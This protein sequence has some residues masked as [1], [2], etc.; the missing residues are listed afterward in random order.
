MNNLVFIKHIGDK[1]CYLFEVPMSVN[2][3]KEDKVFCDTMYARQFGE[4]ITDS[5]Y[6]DD[7]SRMC[8]I[9]GVGAYEPLA[10]VVGYAVEE[11]V[12]KQDLFDKSLPF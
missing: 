1:K 9:A 7:M 8:I 5:F 3:K 11:K 6:V 2:L 10:Q 12:Y 4:C